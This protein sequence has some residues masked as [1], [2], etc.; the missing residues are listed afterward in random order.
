MTGRDPS[1]DIGFE[2]FH[3]L[4]QSIRLGIR[5]AAGKVIFAV[6]SFHPAS[7]I[8]SGQRREGGF[9]RCEGEESVVVSGG[10]AGAITPLLGRP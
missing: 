3:R 5:D 6:I 1:I 2:F 8:V 10:C 9:S 4:E 7:I